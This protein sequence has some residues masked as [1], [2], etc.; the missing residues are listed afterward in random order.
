MRT[1]TREQREA[2]KRIYDRCPLDANHDRIQSGYESTSPY[3]DKLTPISYR[4]FRKAV[5]PILC[6]RAVMVH[7][8]GMFLGIEPDGYTHS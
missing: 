5:Q 1:L 7:W 8:C 2:V 4:Q 6:D 3:N